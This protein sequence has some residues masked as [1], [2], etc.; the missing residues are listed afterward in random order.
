MFQ[1]TPRTHGSQ[2]P[3]SQ[4]DEQQ[5]RDQQALDAVD[6]SARRMMSDAQLRSLELQRQNVDGKVEE[7]RTKERQGS[8]AQQ[9]ADKAKE[10]TV[11]NLDFELGQLVPPTFN[12][13]RRGEIRLAYMRAVDTQAKEIEA[14]RVDQDEQQATEKRSL[15]DRERRDRE[16]VFE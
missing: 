14:K 16:L 9:V 15:V 13:D 4:R 10:N 7:V 2:D 8:S 3:T 5:K 1:N 12:E 6:E 11:G